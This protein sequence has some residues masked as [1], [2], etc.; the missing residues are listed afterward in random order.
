MLSTYLVL[1]K[2]VEE[3]KRTLRRAGEVLPEGFFNAIYATHIA[4]AEV[5]YLPTVPNLP[6]PHPVGRVKPRSAAEDWFAIGFD[7]WSAGKDPL[8]REFI[9]TLMTKE[10]SLLEQQRKR[11]DDAFI[12]VMDQEGMQ[13]DAAEASAQ[14][15]LLAVFA[16]LASHARHGK[17][18][19]IEDA[20]NQPDYNLP[21]DFQDD[22]GNTLLLIAAQNGN[23]RIA[24]LCLRR[25]ATINKQNLAGQTVLHYAYGYGFQEVF[26]YFVSKG[27]DDSLKNADG[28]CAFFLLLPDLILLHV[29]TGAPS[30]LF[31]VFDARSDMLRGPGH[32]G[33]VRHLSS[34]H[35]GRATGGP[36][37][38]LASSALFLPI[39]RYFYFFF[40]SSYLRV[41][42]VLVLAL[43]S[44]VKSFAFASRLSALAGGPS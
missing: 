29:L 37:M 35:R 42:V 24:K 13:R 14:Q 36:F 34:K 2:F 16:E 23:K 25:G 39:S 3:S 4:K 32:E 6:Q 33:R 7:P 26:E 10:E 38:S 40:A 22:M 43:V 30:F 41:G 17:Y 19:E 1:Q 9:P 8:S 20:M 31:L 12:E 15:K 27:A 18:R 5:D 21:I 28:R 44:C 11:A